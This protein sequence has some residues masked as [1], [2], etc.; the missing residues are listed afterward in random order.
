MA[1]GDRGSSA[2]G[3][4]LVASGDRGS[5]RDS[6]RNSGRNTRE[7]PRSA[8]NDGIQINGASD[9]F[10]AFAMEGVELSGLGAIELEEE[11]IVVPPVEEYES[12]DHPFDEHE[13]DRY[14][15]RCWGR[16]S[17]VG[18]HCV[19]GMKLIDMLNMLTF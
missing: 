19:S 2:R 7:K 18:G 10:E 3:S 5:F 9:G 16:D 12:D 17:C 6:G 15:A 1:S 14:G 4:A 13:H 8:G 11:E